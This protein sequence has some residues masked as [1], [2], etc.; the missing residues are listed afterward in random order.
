MRLFWWYNKLLTLYSTLHTMMPNIFDYQNALIGCN[1]FSN[2]LGRENII[3]F[4]YHD[5]DLFRDCPLAKWHRRGKTS[6]GLKSN[7]VMPTR[8]LVTSVNR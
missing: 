2:I 5:Y 1:S 3:V 8:I 6:R 7:Q 4:L